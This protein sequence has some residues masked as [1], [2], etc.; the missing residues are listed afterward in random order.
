MARR[1]AFLFFIIFAI[2][3]PFVFSASLDGLVDPAYA[4]QLRS[5]AS[6]SET[7][8]RNPI[9][10]LLPKHDE[11]RQFVT[12]AISSLDPN[13]AVETLYLYKKPASSNYWNNAQRS[14]LF[15]QTLAISTL[16]GIQYFSA[17]RNTMRTFY[18]T[19]GVIDG[20]QTKK[21]L[22]DPVYPQPPGSLTL[23]ARQKDLTFGDNI[24][25]YD[26]KLVQD[27]FFFSQENETA[28][29]YGIIPAVGKNRL[30]SVFTVIDCGDSL[31]IY[32]VSIAK[33]AALPGMGDRISN[34]FGNRAE[35]VFKWFTAKADKVF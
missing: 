33:T 16:T 14:D 12:G 7:Q 19:S 27:A 5:G 26:F 35:A 15:N 34:S 22:P 11:L 25:R 6:V 31:L 18:E 2:R 20:P 4:A 1:A 23:Y 9:L 29:S 24:Y 21:P 32:A 3:V 13:L 17:T 8:L 10:K 30:R 28:L